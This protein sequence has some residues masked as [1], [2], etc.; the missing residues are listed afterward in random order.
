MSSAYVQYNNN[1]FPSAYERGFGY[2]THNSDPFNVYN[3][4]SG[5]SNSNSFY[6]HN[7]QSY[8]G[9]VG[10]ISHNEEYYSCNFL[11]KSNNLLSDGSTDEYLSSPPQSSIASSPESTYNSPVIGFPSPDYY[12]A[13][14]KTEITE[15]VPVANS[16]KHVS[17]K[18]KQP[19]LDIS[20]HEPP[21]KLSRIQVPA[22]LSDYVS[23]LAFPSPSSTDSGSG[24]ITVG[25]E[26]VRR[27]RLAA[28][29]RERRR[30]N[31]LNDAFDQLR[32]VVPSLGSDRK[33]SKYETL[34]MAQTYIAA[35]NELLT[36]DWWVLIIV[37][38]ELKTVRPI[39]SV[40]LSTRYQIL[41]DR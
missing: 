31:S 8:G 30:M 1:C 5:S 32:D 40:I 26:I 4:A 10:T 17:L 13:V 29:A 23:N 11:N 9:G 27:R 20:K 38:A 34:Q 35:L 21:L 25:P 15:Q 24:L 12:K 37:H 14:C 6:H 39:I 41:N 18:R 2:N 16:P 22:K 7:H 33:L 36:R 19:F 28:N 3:P